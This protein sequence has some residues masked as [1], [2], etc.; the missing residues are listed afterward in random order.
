MGQ[1]HNC[2]NVIRA[3]V[4]SSSSVDRSPCLEQVGKWGTDPPFPHQYGYQTSEQSG[5]GPTSLCLQPVA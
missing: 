3:E 2:E 1:G 5:D 4:S